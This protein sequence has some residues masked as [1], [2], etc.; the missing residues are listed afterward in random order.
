MNFYNQIGKMAL[1]SRLRALSNNITN[2]AADIYKL[3]DIEMQPRWFPVFYVLS[4]TDESSITAIAKEIGQTHPSVSQVVREMVKHGFAIEKKSKED[5]RKNYVA[6]SAKGKDAAVKIQAQYQDVEAAIDGAFKESQYDLWKAI[7]EWEYLLEQKSLFKRVQDERKKRESGNVTIIDYSPEY[8]SAFRELN[9]EW[10]SQYFSMEESDYKAL[11][12]PNEYIIDKGGY[13]FIALYEGDALGTCAL[14]KMDDHK[15]ELA[16]MAVSPKAQGKN[17]GTLLGQ[18]AIAKCKALG[19]DTIYLE[20]N[21]ILK[22]AIN[23]YRKLGFEKITGTPSPYARCN[24]Q[25]ELK[26]V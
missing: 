7:E 18:A 5:Q 26:I 25:M 24:I 19:A 10:I 15:Y 1:G 23:L 8:Q 20:S 21:T 9:V 12:H 22:P 2:D 17:I 16:K 11:D 3:Y 13:I 14:I 6:L 4:K